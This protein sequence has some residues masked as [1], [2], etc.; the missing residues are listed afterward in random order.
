M[1]KGT[2][3]VIEGGDGSG[4]S[5]VASIV[6]HQLRSQGLTVL[7]TREPGGTEVGVSIRDILLHEDIGCMTELLLFL[8]DRSEHV[9]KVMRPAL[10]QGSVVICDRFSMTT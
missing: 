6:A 5:T 7:N 4:K 8:A 2:F 1:Q 10:E 9:E 3:V